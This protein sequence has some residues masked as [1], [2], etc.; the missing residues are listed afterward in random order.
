MFVCACVHMCV[1]LCVHMLMY[2]YVCMCTHVCMF[3]CAYV[4]VCL[5]VHMLMYV[6]VCRWNDV[7]MHWNSSC[8][9]LN[10]TLLHLEA[11][12]AEMRHVLLI[13]GEEFEWLEE[14]EQNT[15]IRNRTHGNLELLY[16]E[17]ERHEVKGIILYTGFMSRR[18]KNEKV[19][20]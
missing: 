1:C 12:E 9:L 14:C 2:V 18:I 15:N 4:D 3:V 16:K 13:R 6:C 20:F 5:C 7:Q 11:T 17:I 19:L 8:K 10:E